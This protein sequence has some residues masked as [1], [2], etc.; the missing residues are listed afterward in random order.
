MMFLCKEGDSAIEGERVV[1]T[2]CREHYGDNARDEI[3]YVSFEESIIDTRDDKFEILSFTKGKI[4]KCGWGS[5]TGVDL[6]V[7]EDKKY[8]ICFEYT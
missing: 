8:E 7:F 5:T 3:W 1:S 4:S 2:V 6:V